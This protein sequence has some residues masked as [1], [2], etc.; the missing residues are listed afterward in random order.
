MYHI[1]RMKD[2]FK[3]LHNHLQLQATNSGKF[4]LFLFYDKYFLI[5]LVMAF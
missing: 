4:S 5:F 2:L 1:N 3:K